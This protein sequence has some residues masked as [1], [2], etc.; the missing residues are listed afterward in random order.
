MVVREDAAGTQLEELMH[1]LA[2]EGT[3]S[4]GAGLIE[5]TRGTLLLTQA[6]GTRTLAVTAGVFWAARLGVIV[7]SPGKIIAPGEVGTLNVTRILQ[8]EALREEIHGDRDNK[9]AC[10]GLTT[11]YQQSLR[12]GLDRPLLIMGIPTTPSSQR[13]HSRRCGR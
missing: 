8:K 3:Y 9:G 1:R 11:S 4:K 13:S 7:G 12:S 10:G 2:A 5:P 6:A